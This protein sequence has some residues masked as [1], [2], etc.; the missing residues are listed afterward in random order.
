MGHNGAGRYVIQ[1]ADAPQRH[2]SQIKANGR[3]SYFKAELQS[4]RFRFAGASVA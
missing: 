1:C 2:A 4:L 3:A